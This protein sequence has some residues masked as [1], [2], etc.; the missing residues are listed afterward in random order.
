MAAG[1]V[2]AS[3]AIWVAA[4]RVLRHQLDQGITGW[5]VLAARE[6][7]P[8][9]RC[10]ERDSAM[11]F[12]AT[13]Y[14]R[15]INRYIVFRDPTCS[16]T[17]AIPLWAADLPVDTAALGA[18]RMDAPTF[19]EGIWHGSKV[20]SVYVATDAEPPTDGRHRVIQVAASLAPVHNLERDMLLALLGIVILGTG[21]TLFGASRLAGSAVRP[22]IEITEQATHIAAGTLDQRLSAHATA[23]EYRGLVGVLNGMLDRLSSAFAVQRR[24]TTD[25][26]HELRTP[27]TAL[28]GEI[29]V[30]L[31]NERSPR[32]YQRVLH[33]ALEEIERMTTMTE[34]LLLINRAESRQLVLRPEPTDLLALAR[35][36]MDGFRHRIAEKELRTVCVAGD[37]DARPQVDAELMRRLLD[38]LLD[39]AITYSE[40]GGAVTVRLERGP[41][42]ERLVVEDTGPGV[43]A[44]DLPH[45]FEPYFRA[46][47]ARTRGAGTGL[48]LTA[49][50]AIARLHG[51]AIRAMNRPSGGARFEVELPVPVG[52]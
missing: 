42:L 34:E 16:V 38:E 25:V 51:G 9:S 19:S 37:G 14:Q 52:A 15:Q 27:L 49:A 2:V 30:T 33:S 47:R 8:S 22:V 21:A 44:A 23:E 41:G 46:D 13:R 10:N 28:Q 1:L 20:R 18:A 36:A 4:S 31:R 45:L 43:A 35:D 39:N 40:F 3:A 26:S 24:F 17:R 11:T 29:E 7:A 50:L 12:D 48:G 6:L 32:E 5:A